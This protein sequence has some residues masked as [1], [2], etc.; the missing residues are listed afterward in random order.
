[1][2]DI[3][4]HAASFTLTLFFLYLTHK[5]KLLSSPRSY[6]GQCYK[7]MFGRQHSQ[8]E[9]SPRVKKWKKVCSDA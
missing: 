7:I 6:R 2:E 8:I 1:M 9:K 3:N 5:R 4:M